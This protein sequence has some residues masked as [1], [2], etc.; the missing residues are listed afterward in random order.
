MRVFKSQQKGN[1]TKIMYNPQPVW[2]HAEPS[3]LLPWLKRK[4]KKKKRAAVR[5][6]ERSITHLQFLSACLW[7]HHVCSEGCV[8][9]DSCM[10]ICEGHHGK[11]HSLPAPSLSHTHTGVTYIYHYVNEQMASM[12]NSYTL[13]SHL[14]KKHFPVFSAYDASAYA[15]DTIHLHVLFPQ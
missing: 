4:K 13:Q 15:C 7:S 3:L 8:A 11:Y 6:E 12:A 10:V 1:C 2:T 9:M 14:N 5:G